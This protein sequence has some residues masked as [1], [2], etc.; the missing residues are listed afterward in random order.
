MKKHLFAIGVVAMAATSLMTIS[1]NSGKDKAGAGQQADSTAVT[2]STAV[3]DSLATANAAQPEAEEAAPGDRPTFDLV[4]N[5]KTCKWKNKDDSG[6]TT[7]YAFDKDGKL[8]TI[9][10]QREEMERN[11]KGQIKRYSEGENGLTSYT[12]EYDAQGRVK[13]SEMYDADSGNDK[14]TYT[15]DAKGLVTSRFCKGEISEM[16]E[17]NPETYTE[18]VTYEYKA[19]DEKGNWTK[20]VCHGATGRDPWTETRTIVYY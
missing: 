9:N 7:S 19:V 8:T 4:G 6:N 16:G 13:K 17:D 14:Y 20:R 18:N 11:K 5:V 10:G 2:D 3:A 12:F 1:C 15:Y